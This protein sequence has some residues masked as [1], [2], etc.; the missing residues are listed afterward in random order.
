MRIGVVAALTALGVAGTAQAGTVKTLFTSTA[1]VGRSVSGRI[2]PVTEGYLGAGVGVTLYAKPAA[3]GG[4]WSASDIWFPS[5][6][7]GEGAYPV[8]GVA[9]AGTSFYVATSGGGDTACPNG[10]G[11]VNRLDRAGSGWTVTQLTR[12]HL[13]T[14]GYTPTGLPRVVNGRVYGVTRS[15]TNDTPLPNSSEGPMGGTVYMLAPAAGGGM[16]ASV[17]HHF[18]G[19][20]RDGVLP[21]GELAVKPGTRPTLYGTTFLGGRCGQGT[22]F[23]LR[24]PA[25]TGGAWT[26][27]LL[28]EFGWNGTNCDYGD[29]SQPVAGVIFAQ[30]MLYGSTRAATSTECGT[31]FSIN[32]ATGA[33]RKLATFGDNAADACS[34]QA[35]LRISATTGVISGTS[36]LGGGTTGVACPRGCGTVFRLTPDGAGGYTKS[37][38]YAFTG[39]TD[40]LAP[41]SSL[42]ASGTALIGAAQHGGVVGDLAKND[43]DTFGA[44]VSVTP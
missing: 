25:T 43:Y 32:T 23:S 8:G 1:T 14:I 13:D 31:V 33:Y 7:N 20:S 24:A 34:P 29:G 6:L 28:H 16:T 2:A 19:A 27:A 9:A 5:G 4:A 39:G 3:R 36:A 21:A 42:A 15:A 12:F 44:L 18:D 30:G 38:L 22:V 17:L 11:T 10:C 26:Y 41:R 35:P 40:G 37:V